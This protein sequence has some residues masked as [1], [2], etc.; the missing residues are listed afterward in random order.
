MILRIE[1][2][3][4]FGYGFL[5]SAPSDAVLAVDHIFAFYGRSPIKICHPHEAESVPKRSVKYCLLFTC[6][7]DKN[8]NLNTKGLKYLSRNTA[9]KTSNTTESQKSVLEPTSDADW[10]AFM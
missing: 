3:T 9:K 2:S 10:A 6:V 8:L 7:V 1:I 5:Y 4:T